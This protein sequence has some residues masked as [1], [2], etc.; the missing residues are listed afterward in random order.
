MLFQSADI[1]Q[2]GLLTFAELALKVVPQNSFDED[3][4]IFFL[5]AMNTRSSVTKAATGI[6]Y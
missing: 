2:D 3:V 5:I 4:V 1:N 6:K